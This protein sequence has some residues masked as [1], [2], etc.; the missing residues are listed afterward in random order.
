MDNIN[1]L[2]LFAKENKEIITLVCP[3]CGKEFQSYRLIEILHK[4]NYP[5]EDKPICADCRK[6]QVD[7]MNE[8]MKQA[9][10]KE[11]SERIEKWK[12]ESGIPPRYQEKRFSNFSVT[13]ENKKAYSVCFEYAKSFP[14][15]KAIKYTSLALI[16][17]LKWGVGKTHLVCSIAH[18]IIE[19]CLYSRNPICYMTEYQL[20]TRLRATFEHQEDSESEQEFYNYVCSVP[21]LIIDDVGKEEVADPRFVQRVWFQIVNSRYDN[22]LPI[23]IT[24]NKTPDMIAQHLGGSRNNEAVFDR[25]YEMINGVF[26]AVGGESYRRINHANQ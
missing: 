13:R 7:K 24:A 9:I 23:V 12:L 17:E 4:K 1:N 5:N 21:L 22:L 20:F 16:S 2:N 10:A 15:F 25:L 14:N 8:E 6:P 3:Q 19:N 11:K 26:Y 18:E